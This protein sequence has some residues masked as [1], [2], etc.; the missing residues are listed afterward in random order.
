MRVT[1]TVREYIEK[2][3]SA[4]FPAEKELPEV[5]IYERAKE[6]REKLIE[7]A[8]ACLQ[9]LADKYVKEINSEMLE[10]MGITEFAIS[11]HY[12]W[13]SNAPAYQAAQK[14]KSDRNVAIKTAIDDIVVALEL[15]GTK[16]TLDKM[17]KELAERV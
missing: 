2:Q 5:V 16:D 3:V 10:G 6:M 12:P 17:L 8:E 14:A 7:E 1:K 15:G 13:S 4:L 11:A 9:A